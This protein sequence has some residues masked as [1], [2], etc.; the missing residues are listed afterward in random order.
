MINP[1]PDDY[2]DEP[3]FEGDRELGRQMYSGA[4]VLRGKM[5]VKRWRRFLNKAAGALGMSPAGKDAIW[6]YPVSGKGGNGDTICQPITESFLVLDT[7]P[8]FRGA[9]LFVCSCRP[10][11]PEKLR[12]L[13]STFGLE[14]QNMS[15]FETMRID[16]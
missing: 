9:Y 16:A 4:L 13:S 7:W 14:V 1:D 15:V 10:F 3:D 12:D 11:E 6:H 8:D 2:P 5:E